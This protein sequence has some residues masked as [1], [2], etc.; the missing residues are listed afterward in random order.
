MPQDRKPGDPAI[1]RAK[2]GDVEDVSWALST[3]EAMWGRGDRADALKWVRRAAEAASEAERDERALEIAKAAADLAQI[4]ER[5]ASMPPPAAA[6]SQMPATLG[7]AAPSPSG[8]P[9]AYSQGNAGTVRQGSSS[10]INRTSQPAAVAVAPQKGTAPL[11]QASRASHSDMARKPRKSVSADEVPRD[12]RKMQAPMRKPS[13]TNE[14]VSSRRPSAT[15]EGQRK[16]RSTIPP[17][18]EDTSD[19]TNV[20]V[21]APPSAPPPSGRGTQPQSP[22]EM[23]GWPTQ[24]LEGDALSGLAEEMTRVGM[25]AF[26]GTDRNPSAVPPP[27]KSSVRPPPATHASEASAARPSQAVRVVVWRVGDDVHV[28]PQGTAVSAITVDALLVALDPAADLASW[29]GKK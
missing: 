20:N 6:P 24:A 13:M 3:A 7:S 22:E 14:Q 1:P 28:A 11:P 9:G 2:D 4:V 27:S 25:D 5:A 26:E 12:T 21:P 10:K 29:L 23:E 19:T 16:R 8:S 15:S 17:P 18:R